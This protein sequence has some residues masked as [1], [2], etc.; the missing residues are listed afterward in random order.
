MEWKKQHPRGRLPTC[1]LLF[2]PRASLRF[3][4]VNPKRRNDC[5]RPTGRPVTRGSQGVRREG[6][7]SSLRARLISFPATSRSR[8]STQSQRSFGR[9]ELDTLTKAESRFS[10]RLADEGIQR[11]REYQGQKI[12]LSGGE[13]K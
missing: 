13:S 3:S 7:P 12:T 10:L 8:S 11:A 4:R 2:S 9:S 1:R 6:N 5:F